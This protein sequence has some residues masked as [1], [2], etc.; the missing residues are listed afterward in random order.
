[1][2]KT[3]LIMAGGI[4]SR[5]GAGMPKQF[6][7][8]L[9]IPMLWWSVRAFAR[10]DNH[11]RIIIVVHPEYCDTLKRLI[12]E[13]PEADRNINVEITEGGDTRGDSVRAGL[14]LIEDSND[15]L[16]AVHDAARPLIDKS[17]IRRCW[18]QAGNG[19]ALPAVAVT[20]SL[21]ELDNDGTSHAI[22][23]SRY[24]A[25]QT[26][27]IATSA[28]LHKAYRLE[29]RAEF[30]DDASRIEALGGTVNIVEGMPENIKVTHPLDFTIAEA[31]LR[32][33]MR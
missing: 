8:L 22:D 10:E 7:K 26:P 12:A 5:A 2:N 11:T 25:V 14:A 16:V 4:G 3:A 29:E 32:S 24:M 1:M 31:I 20:D 13:L 27:Q 18:E 9:G 30:T 21:R 28:I 17:L 23:R 15:M 6:F 33:K 19:V